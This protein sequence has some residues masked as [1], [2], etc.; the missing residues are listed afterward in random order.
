MTTETIPD[1]TKRDFKKILNLKKNDIINYANEKYKIT[2][3]HYID[4]QYSPYINNNCIEYNDNE[5]TL[6]F[7]NLKN[8]NNNQVF[9][10]QSLQDMI[11]FL[12]ITQESMNAYNEYKEKEKEKEGKGN[13]I[14]LNEYIKRYYDEIKE[15]SKSFKYIA[16]KNM[17]LSYNGKEKTGQLFIEFLIDAKNNGCKIEKNRYFVEETKRGRLKGIEKDALHL[18]DCNICV[19]IN[20]SITAF[21][22]RIKTKKELQNERD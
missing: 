5:C 12:D 18:K 16:N 21:Y 11:N 1:N 13:K 20:K 9:Q 14:T 6:P 2:F 19:R 3:I 15:Q 4:N 10:Y 22:N 7:Y 8:I 17:R